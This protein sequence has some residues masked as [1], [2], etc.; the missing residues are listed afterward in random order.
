MVLRLGGALRG[1]SDKP[2][3]IDE[4]GRSSI[5]LLRK[6]NEIW[7]ST[8]HQRLLT[9]WS[10]LYFG[11]PYVLDPE[12]FAF[13]DDVQSSEESDEYAQTIRPLMKRR[14][15]VRACEGRK[16]INRQTSMLVGRGRFPQM[17]I[18]GIDKVRITES[19][20][21]FEEVLEKAKFRAM[22]RSAIRWMCIEGSAA[23]TSG[24]VSTAVSCRSRG[25]EN[26]LISTRTSRAGAATQI[27]A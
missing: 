26:R 10:A 8:S 21:Q 22:M 24:G 19:T 11:N 15:N 5:A 4:D 16:L 12:L 17:W 25:A 9:F 6:H 27:R 14:P 13:E 23:A 2:N 20:K 1:M 18:E 7:G 3:R